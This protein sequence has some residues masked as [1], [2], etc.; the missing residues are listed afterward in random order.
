[1]RVRSGTSTRWW[2][3]VQVVVPADRATAVPGRI[4]WAAARAMPSF[5]G[6]CRTDLAANPGSSVDPGPAT[7]APPCTF[8]IEAPVGQRLEVAAD[9]HVGDAEVADEVGDPHPAHAADP[10]EDRLLPLLRQHRP[11]SPHT[12]QQIIS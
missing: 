7:V 8:S 4:R 5:S 9:R 12:F 11:S 10:F 2:A 3:K 1:M 6:C